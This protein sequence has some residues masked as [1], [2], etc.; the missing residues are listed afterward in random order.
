[1]AATGP[2][3][4]D[5]GFKS[6]GSGLELGAVFK[7]EGMPFRLGAAVRSALRTVATSRQGLSPGAN[8]DLVVQTPGGPAAYLP[9]TVTLPWDLNFGFAVQLGKRPFNPPWRSTSDLIERE[10]LLHR[11]RTIDREEDL[12]RRLAAAK[13]QD[14]ANAI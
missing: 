3:R 13:T 4:E 10:T 6:T 9:K 8:G 12:A 5:S 11:V 1:M 2:T 14:E 7:P